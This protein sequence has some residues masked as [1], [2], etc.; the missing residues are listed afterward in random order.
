[1]GENIQRGAS[2]RDSK[3]SIQ[4]LCS[5]AIMTSVTAVMAQISIPMPIGVPLTMQTFAVTL[6]AILLGARKGMTAMIVYILLGAAG[7]PVFSNFSGGVHHLLGPTGGFLF[8]FPI[9]AWMIGWGSEQKTK[10]WLGT[11]MLVLGTAANLFVGS[12][13][14]C[15]LMK[16][17]LA[18]SF[19]ICVI[20]FLPLAVLKAFGAAVLGMKLRKRLIKIVRSKN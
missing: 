20:P 17:S 9:M 1:M 12:L 7:V 6:T 16:T 13:Y 11:I 14:Y 3:Y 8:S 18:A 2:M 4:D 19:T 5:I 15:F 10:K